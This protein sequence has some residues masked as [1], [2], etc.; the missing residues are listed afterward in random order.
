MPHR[1]GHVTQQ[2]VSSGQAALIGAQRF[3]EF[4]ELLAG[5]EG[6]FGLGGGPTLEPETKAGLTTTAIQ[7]RASVGK[8]FGVKEFGILVLQAKQAQAA[9]RKRLRSEREERRKRQTTETILTSRRR[10][11]APSPSLKPTLSAVASTS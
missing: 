1:P 9:E 3:R 4:Q 7:A 11:A 6:F 8:A 2:S 5:P 10:R